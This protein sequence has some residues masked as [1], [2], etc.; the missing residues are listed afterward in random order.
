MI[1]AAKSMEIELKLILP[2]TQAEAAVVDCLRQ[3]KYCVDKISPLK[4][5]GYLH[6]YYRLGAP[7]KQTIAPVPF[8]E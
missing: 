3:H 8:V 2:G 4:N 6:G 5:I 7:E 1:D